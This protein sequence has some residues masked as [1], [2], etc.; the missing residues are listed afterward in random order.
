[1]AGKTVPNLTSESSL[2]SSGEILVYDTT[3]KRAAISAFKTFLGLGPLASLDKPLSTTHG[4]T[5]KSYSGGVVDIVS[6]L[7]SSGTDGDVIIYTGEDIRRYS[8]DVNETSKPSST[9]QS[10]GFCVASNGDEYAVQGAEAARQNYTDSLVYRRA[11]GASSWDLSAVSLTMPPDSSTLSTLYTVYWITSG[12]AVKD[13]VVYL[14]CAQ[15]GKVGGTDTYVKWAAYNFTTGAKVGND[16]NETPTAS[17]VQAGLAIDGDGNLFAGIGNKIY[18]LASGE[19][20]WINVHTGPT[21]HEIRSVLYEPRTSELFYLTEHSST[22]GFLLWRITSA[23]TVVPVMHVYDKGTSAYYGGG[24]RTGGQ[25][26]LARQT[27][28]RVFSVSGANRPLWGGLLI[29]KGNT[30]S[31]VEGRA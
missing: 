9:W 29:R 2:S 11:S 8:F 13:G 1:M 21:T 23:T 18:R 7:P 12:I 6:S 24:F 16:I 19:T 25:L 14:L 5:G 3:L 28:W 10:T 27:T 15:K 22:G 17:D 20:G 4:G 31:N 30:W 26:V